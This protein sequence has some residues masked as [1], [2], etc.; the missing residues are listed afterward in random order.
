MGLRTVD[1]H[2]AAA[3][4]VAAGVDYRLVVDAAVEVCIEEL[5]IAVVVVVRIVEVVH[6]PVGVVGAAELHSPE[7]KQVVHI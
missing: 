6:I 4:A 2:A 7:I 3:A 1:T 5:H